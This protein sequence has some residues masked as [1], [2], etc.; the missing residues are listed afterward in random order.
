MMAFVCYATR[1]GG[2]TLDSDAEGGNPLAAGA[3][4]FAVSRR[5]MT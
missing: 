1:A 2:T 4:A 3:V 5:R